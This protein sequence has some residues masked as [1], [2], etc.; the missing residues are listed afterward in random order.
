MPRKKV[1]VVTRPDPERPAGLEIW[2]P[3]LSLEDNI[4]LNRRI[5]TPKDQYVKFSDVVH[6]L[7]PDFPL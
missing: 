3:E 1:A 2:D 5:A 6:R 7:L 4:E